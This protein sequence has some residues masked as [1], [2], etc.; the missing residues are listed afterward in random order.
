MRCYEARRRSDLRESDRIG[1]L[2]KVSFLRFFFFILADALLWHEEK[3]LGYDISVKSD[4][5][6]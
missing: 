5:Y 6:T 1:S 3:T 4:L 2:F